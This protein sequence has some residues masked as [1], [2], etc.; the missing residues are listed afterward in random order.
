MIGNH[1]YGG[2]ASYV[3]AQIQRTE[4]DQY[5]TMPSTNYSKIYE[6]SD[7][8]RVGLVFVDT[9]TLAP[10]ENKC[11]NTNGGISQETQY[12]RIQNQLTCIENMFK[13]M[14]IAQVSWLVVLGHYPIYSKGEHGDTDELVDYLVPLFLKY[15][16]N[17][18]FCGHDHL[19][20]K[21][22]SLSLSLL[23]LIIIFNSEHLIKDDI[24]YFVAGI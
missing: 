8:L 9:T 17:V 3:Q 5:W 13:K 4:I 16:V 21:I 12:N 7:N 10:S 23:S 6:L 18:Y 24:H 15:K 22:L 20:L 11:C 14:Q 2:G 1:D 19:R